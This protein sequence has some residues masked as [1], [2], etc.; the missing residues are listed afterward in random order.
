MEKM[1]SVFLMC[2][3]LFG[4]VGC[5]EKENADD[6]KAIEIQGKIDKAKWTVDLERDAGFEGDYL[7]IKLNDYNS[8]NIIRNPNNNTIDTVN[9]YDGH[10]YDMY[11]VRYMLDDKT[12]RAA[13]NINHAGEKKDSCLNYDL[14]NNEVDESFELKGSCTVDEIKYFKSVTILRDGNLKDAKIKLDD[15]AVWAEWY[16]KNN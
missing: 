10:E 5:G 3:M 16:Y 12:D 7:K 11:M 1:L 6:K 13:H 14:T 2:G 4:I 8:F 15:L 9:Y